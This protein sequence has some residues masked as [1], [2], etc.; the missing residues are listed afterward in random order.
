MNLMKNTKLTKKP[1]KTTTSSKKE[2]NVIFEERIIVRPEVIDYLNEGDLAEIIQNIVQMAK[3]GD[4]LSVKFI[5]DRSTNPPPEG[6]R[7]PYNLPDI[8]NLEDVEKSHAKVIKCMSEGSI[9]PQEAKNVCSVIDSLFR[10]K[11]ARMIEE[12]SKELINRLPSK[13]LKI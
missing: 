7:R 13:M 8:E 1:A 6:H 4:P 12:R 5:S 10:V 2:K 9:S 3:E 11:E